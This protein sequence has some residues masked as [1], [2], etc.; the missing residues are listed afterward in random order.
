MQ[1]FVLFCC[2]MCIVQ[3]CLGNNSGEEMEEKIVREVK[4]RR[5]LPTSLIEYPGILFRNEGVCG[6]CSRTEYDLDDLSFNVDEDLEGGDDVGEGDS[7]LPAKFLLKFKCNNPKG[8]GGDD[9]PIPYEGVYCF[10]SDG[11]KDCLEVIEV[12]KD[13]DDVALVDF[14]ELRSYSCMKNEPNAYERGCN[15]QKYTRNVQE[16]RRQDCKFI[17]GRKIF[18]QMSSSRKKECAGDLGN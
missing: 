14:T 2:C 18:N 11:E 8:C 16:C 12:V 17:H 7:F 3:I 9:A 1:A 6:G 10:Q 15:C 5:F 4:A 13:T